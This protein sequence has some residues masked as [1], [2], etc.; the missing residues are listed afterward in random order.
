MK[1]SLINFPSSF[2]FNTVTEF[3]GLDVKLANT[4]CINPG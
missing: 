4:N 2:L 3:R 1:L